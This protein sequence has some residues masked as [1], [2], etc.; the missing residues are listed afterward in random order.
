MQDHDVKKIKKYLGMGHTGQKT[1]ILH[2]AQISK[3]RRKQ[4]A[5]YHALC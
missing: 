4:I 3:E 2:D 5:R 1:I